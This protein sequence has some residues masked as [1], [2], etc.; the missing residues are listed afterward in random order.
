MSKTFADIAD[1][2]R[3]T[4]QPNINDDLPYIG[5]EHIDQQSLQFLG[6]GSSKSVV[7]TKKRFQS[8]DILFGTLRPYFRK[9]VL[10]KNSG[11]CSTDIAVIR[12]KPGVSARFVQY[13][14]ADR[15]FID[16]SMGT[17]NGTRMPRAKWN[18]VSSY[19]LPP[20]FSQSM[21]ERIGGLLGA[22]DDLI[23][24]NSKRMEKLEAMARLLYRHYFEVPEADDWDVKPLKEVATLVMGQSPK[25]EFYNNKGLGLPFHQGVTN[26]GARFITHQTYSTYGSRTAEPGDILFSVRAPVGHLNLTKDKIILG[27]GLSAI[28]HNHGYQSLL[29]EQLKSKFTKKDMMGSGTIFASVT[30]KD[31]ENIQISCPSPNIQSELEQ[32]LTNIHQ[33]IGVLDEKNRILTKT[34]DLLLPRLM[35]GEIQV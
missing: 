1:D 11:V 8:G 19:P 16:H 30:K 12:P 21:S 3:N 17:S 15:K 5:L 6:V 25:S 7:S 22:Y 24:N 34:R 4:Y 9:V 32:K 2:V 13:M 29:W 26:F 35:S 28:R 27:R 18:I 10:A 20:N 33:L 14:I 31:M 23:E